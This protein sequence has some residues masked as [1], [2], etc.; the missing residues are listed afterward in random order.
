VKNNYNFAD[1]LLK[2]SEAWNI[3]KE[4]RSAAI[5]SYMDQDEWRGT[6]QS[7]INAVDSRLES[8]YRFSTLVRHLE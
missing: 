3:Y 1:A 6:I 5:R 7:I 8:Q 4:S 2:E